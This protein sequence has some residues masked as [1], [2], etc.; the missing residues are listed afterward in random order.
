MLG[1]SSEAA[2]RR[3][4]RIADGFVPTAPEIYDFYRDEVQRLG[5][6]DP[7]PGF[8]SPIV[9]VALAED[10][11]SGWEQM[12]AYFLHETNTYGA[13]VQPG[14]PSPYRTMADLDE[15]RASGLYAVLT[16]DQFVEQMKA[17]PIPLAFFHPL[18][19]GMPIDVAW[20]SLH[21]FE[22]QVLPAFA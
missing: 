1:G 4:A 12:G 6:P 20:S 18:C 19:G 2:A 16:P 9:T 11:E 7:G 10:P 8:V 17:A 21:L 3:A 5:R 13:W 15:L 22:T 14:V